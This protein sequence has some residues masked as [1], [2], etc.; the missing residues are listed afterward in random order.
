MTNCSECGTKLWFF[1]KKHEFQDGSIMCTLCFEKWK[2]EEE[3]KKNKPIIMSYISR[4]LSNKTEMR[5]YILALRINR[6][7]N[8]LFEEHSLKRVREYH[9]DW[10]N[11]LEIES[12][13]ASTLS[14]HNLDVILNT[15]KMCNAVLFFLDDLEKMYKLFEK[16]G[17]HTNYFEIISLFAEFIENEKDKEYDK[18]VIPVYKILSKK[19][20]N[21][22]CNESVIKNM[23]KLQN[24]PHIEYD[25]M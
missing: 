3:M 12:Q 6:E 7:R 16:K 17:I 14:R 19:L 15:K 10:L 18:I 24:D 8:A 13:K 5:S 1:T 2:S 4:Y 21:N 20:G 22:V 9:Q 11:E 23:M 25:F